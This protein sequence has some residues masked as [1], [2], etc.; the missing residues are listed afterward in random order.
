[1]KYLGYE[2]YVFKPPPKCVQEKGMYMVAN[3]LPQKKE[4][5][6]VDR[7]RELLRAVRKHP[8]FETIHDWNTYVVGIHN[9][10][11]GMSHFCMNFRKIG[12]RKTA[13]QRET[14]QYAA[15]LFALWYFI[16]L[17]EKQA[18]QRRKGRAG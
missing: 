15:L 6:I 11:K 1:M 13:E 14:R 5:E 8:N 4:D 16:L 17:T 3:T 9:Y 18:H 2:F 7:C 12:W 10:Y